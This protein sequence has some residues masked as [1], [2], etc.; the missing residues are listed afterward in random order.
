MINKFRNYFLSGLVIFLPIALTVYIFFLFINFFDG[1]I[2]NFLEPFFVENFG[3]Y[4]EGINRIAFHFLC[5]IL[6]IY[7]IGLIGFFAANFVGRAIVGLFEK[8]LIKL[9]FSPPDLSGP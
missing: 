6:G 4:F 9:P 2:A 3:F 5:V 8:M 7:S 1:L